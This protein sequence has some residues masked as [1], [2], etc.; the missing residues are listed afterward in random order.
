MDSVNTKELFAVSAPPFWHRGRTISKMMQGL[1]IAL[2]PVCLLAIYTWG[3]PALRVICLSITVCV[4]TEAVCQ[5]L[6]RRDI[7]VDNFDAVYVGLLFAFLLPASAPWWLVTIGAFLCMTFGKMAFGDLG[8]AP[9]SSVCVGYVL[10]IVSFPIYMDAN[11]MQ[12]STYLID[13]LVR[14]KFFG[15][16]YVQDISYTSLLLGQ[17]IGG[18]GASQAGALLVIGL[19]LSAVNILRYEITLSFILGIIIFGDIF[20]YMNPE[21]YMPPLFHLFTGST[22]L[23]AFFLATDHSSSPNKKKNMII[24]GFIGGALVITI[25]NFGI[26]TDGAPFAILLINLIMPLLEG[27]IEKP[28]G[29]E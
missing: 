4:V 13:P 28:L 9:L 18:L 22:I 29:M 20:Y 2:L 8:A 16:D 6:L 10:C 25:R 7:V 24:Y 21:S 15:V 5:K 12:L 1:S 14:L 27:R 3:L 26:Y 23:C 11:A 17:Q 19:L